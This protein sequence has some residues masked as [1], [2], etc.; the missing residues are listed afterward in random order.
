MSFNGSF[1]EG[2]FVDENNSN[3]SFGQDFKVNYDS[4]GTSN[5]KYSNTKLSNNNDLTINSNTNNIF[6]PVPME[7]ETDNDYQNQKN[8]FYDSLL[9]KE[10][11][12]YHISNLFN[13][14]KSKIIIIKYKIF[15]I[16]KEVSNIKLRNL[17]NAEILYI[18]ISSKLKRIVQIFKRNRINILYQV[19][20]ILKTKIYI[21]KNNCD[22]DHDKNSIEKLEKE[23]KDGEKKII[24]LTKQEKKLRDEINCCY[25]KKKQ[26][27]DTIKI[28]ENNAV[29]AA[30][31]I[32]KKQ[33]NSKYD[34]N[35]YSVERTIE[36]NKQTKNGKEEV[37][38]LFMKNINKF[39]NEYQVYIN[40]LYGIESDMN[41]NN[42]NNINNNNNIS[43]NMN[44]DM[45]I[46]LDENINNNK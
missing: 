12:K 38:K 37:D 31:E 6:S 3:L 41:N 23:I 14:I 36:A 4:E 2:E 40:N 11:L 27:K 21:A 29:K 28:I 46:E 7:V 34:S 13:I 25:K 9:S 39:L 20:N 24:I 1:G 30:I 45:N 26:M 35:L 43:N 10:F 8:T 5:L 44:I 33:N 16:I 32:I 22:N 17:I 42:T 18:E 15:S 19:F